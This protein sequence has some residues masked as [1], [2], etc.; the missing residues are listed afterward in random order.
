[1]Q[2]WIMIFEII[3]RLPISYLRV[4]A[5]HLCY[6]LIEVFGPAGVICTTLGSMLVLPSCEILYFRFSKGAAFR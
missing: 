2:Q 6:T 5:T 4:E 1:M 3:G